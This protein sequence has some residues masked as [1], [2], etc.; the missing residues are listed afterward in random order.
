MAD[1]VDFKIFKTNRLGL[2]DLYNDAVR[3]F[4][5]NNGGKL[6]SMK[7]L[8]VQKEKLWVNPDCG[9]KTRGDEETEKSLANLVEAAKQLR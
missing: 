9:L 6:P 2:N 4:K 3:Y 5:E 1:K 7:D 8:K